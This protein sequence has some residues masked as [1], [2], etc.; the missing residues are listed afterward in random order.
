MVCARPAG[1]SQHPSITVS[2]SSQIKSE[3]I[4]AGIKRVVTKGFNIFL[5]LWTFVFAFPYSPFLYALPEGEQ[6]VAGQASF[7]RSHAGTLKV[8]AADKAI[9]N[10]NSFSI[11]Q[12]E[13]VRF[14]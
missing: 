12:P 6:V 7:D 14:I 11:A 13:T 4:Q 10:Y 8:T 1:P 3:Q 2:Q 5:A 9:I